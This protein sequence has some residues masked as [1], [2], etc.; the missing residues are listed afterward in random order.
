M[1]LLNL[2]GCFM[3]RR[4]DFPQKATLRKM[5]S[6][7]LKENDAKVKDGTDVNS[8]MSGMITET[9][10]PITAEMVILKKPCIPAMVI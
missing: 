3:T 5:M 9:R 7:Y 6:S 4:K 2:E 1:K 10:I 8:I